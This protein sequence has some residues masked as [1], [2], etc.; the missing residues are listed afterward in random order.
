MVVV[1]GFDSVGDT[2][3]STITGVP[4]HGGKIRRRVGRRH[5]PRHGEK[6]KT[7]KHMQKERKI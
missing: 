2:L 6:K 3:A 7:M 4:G 1:V 5:K